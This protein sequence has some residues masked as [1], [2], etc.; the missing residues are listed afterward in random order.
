MFPAGSAARTKIDYSGVVYCAHVST[1]KLLVRRNGKQVISGMG[2]LL[3]IENN[4]YAHAV[5][6]GILPSLGI[7]IREYMKLSGDSQIA[8]T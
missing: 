4:A 1:G 8:P 5:L 2:G 6:A 7:F 3:K